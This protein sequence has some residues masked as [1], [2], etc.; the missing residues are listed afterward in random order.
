M[1]GGM[2][3]FTDNQPPTLPSLSVTPATVTVER[4]PTYHISDNEDDNVEEMSGS[5]SSSSSSDSDSDPDRTVVNRTLIPKSSNNG[6]GSSINRTG[7][8]TNGYH[9]SYNN[10]V[11]SN[12]KASSM[13]PTHNV[14]DDL[15]LSEDSD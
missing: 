8:S 11:N 13:Q 9:Q 1:I 14:Y 10:G 4:S 6:S 7:A 15:Q 12:N 5:S 3:D 2:D